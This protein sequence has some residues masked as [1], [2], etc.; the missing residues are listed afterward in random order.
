MFIIIY[1]LNIRVS[2][3]A[4]YVVIG[5]AHDY[6]TCVLSYNSYILSINS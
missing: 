5:I 1:I 2:V 4:V 6:C 3:D